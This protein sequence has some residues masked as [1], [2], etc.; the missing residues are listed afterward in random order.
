VS[1]ALKEGDIEDRGAFFV[2]WY[3]ELRPRTPRRWAFASKLSDGSRDLGAARAGFSTRD[4]AIAAGIEQIYGL[5]PGDVLYYVRD[6]DLYEVQQ[7][8]WQVQSERVEQ[9][10][11]DG[12]TFARL[13]SLSV[14]HPHRALGSS[15]HRT[16]QEAVRAFAAGQRSDVESLRRRIA[17]A[18]RAMAWAAAYLDDGSLAEEGPRGPRCDGRFVAG[19]VASECSRTRGCNLH[20]CPYFTEPCSRSGCDGGCPSIGCDATSGDADE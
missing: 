2:W 18:K 17:E 1:E 16:P 14:I 8:T 13:V 19:G 11:A 9:V 4:R 20:G 3:R 7:H 10:R 15:Y 6:V 12:F 5:H